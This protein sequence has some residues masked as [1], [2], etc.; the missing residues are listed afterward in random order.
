MKVAIV[1][2]SLARYL[3]QYDS[4]WRHELECRRE[5]EFLYEGYPGWSFEEFLEPRGKKKIDALLETKPDIVIGILGAYSIKTTVHRNDILIRAR[6]FYNLLNEKLLAINPKGIIIASQLPLRFR[7]DPNNR[8]NTPDPAT[9]KKIRDK[10]NAKLCDLK[11]IHY[12]LAIGGK[13]SS[14]MKIYLGMAFTLIIRALKCSYTL[15]YVSFIE[16]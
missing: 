1:G 6:E 16:F 11:S 10:I 13:E 15:S 8:H 4:T 2:S 12:V 7:R 5:V 9:F 14:I 3:G